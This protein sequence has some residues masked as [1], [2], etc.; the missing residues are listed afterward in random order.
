VWLLQAGAVHKDAFSWRVSSTYWLFEW[1]DE[2][3]EEFEED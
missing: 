1:E 2:Y 3:E